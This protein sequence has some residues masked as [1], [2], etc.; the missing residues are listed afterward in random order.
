MDGWLMDECMDGRKDGLDAV[1]EGGW[2]DGCFTDPGGNSNISADNKEP[3]VSDLNKS[4]YIAKISYM[5][6]YSLHTCL[7]CINV[8]MR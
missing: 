5:I 4:I 1:W 6:I 3:V 8:L 7:V 2:V